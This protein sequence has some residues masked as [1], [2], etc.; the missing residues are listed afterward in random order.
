MNKNFICKTFCILVLLLSFIQSSPAKEIEEINLK[1]LCAADKL[2]P[3]NKNS[4]DINAKEIAVEVKK[5][6]WNKDP[7]KPPSWG[8]VSTIKISSDGNVYDAMLLTSKKDYIAFSF[9][10]GNDKDRDQNLAYIFEL[11]LNTMEIK[12]TSLLLFS[13]TNNKITS[14]VLFCKRL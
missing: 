4:R 6:D 7:S 11:N 3:I 14:N 1:I 2:T 5:I 9:V 8:S 10:T 12:E 13:Q